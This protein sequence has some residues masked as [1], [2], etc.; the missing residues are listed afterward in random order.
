MARLNRGRYLMAVTGA[1]AA[2]AGLHYFWQRPAG[3]AVDAAWMAHVAGRVAA[4][5]VLYRDTFCGVTPLAFWIQ[6]LAGEWFGHTVGTVRGMLHALFVAQV[7]LVALIGETM[8]VSRLAMGA[9]L[10]GMLLWAAPLTSSTYSAWGV[11]FL[12]GA[13]W[14]A[15][16]APA[17]RRWA[18][19]AGVSAALAFGAKQ[20]VGVLALAMIVLMAPRAS[21]RMVA[22]FGVV[23][24]AIAL[25]VG[26]SGG[27]EEFVY[28][29]FTGKVTYLQTAGVSYWRGVDWRPRAILYL[30]PLGLVG[31]VGV[32]KWWPLVLLAVV[33]LAAVYPRPDPVHMVMAA[34][35]LVL[36]A[37]AVAA[38]HYWLTRGAVLV[39]VVLLVAQIGAEMYWVSQKGPAVVLHQRGLRGDRLEKPDAERIAKDLAALGSYGAGRPLFLLHPD[40]AFFYAGTGLKN[41][42]RYDY[43]LAT[44][45]GPT[46]QARVGAAI[47]AGEIRE[48]CLLES[49][50]PEL[51]PEELIATVRT[52]MRPAE[53]L[54]GAPCRLYRRP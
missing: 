45:F 25:L 3:A 44:T 54:P 2:W 28:Q 39:M 35:G 16:Q 5:E 1:A 49:P 34:P 11:V 4:G 53:E 26:A 41:P 29:C 22:G 31:L 51:P 17:D 24:A 7:L 20:N 38:R 47:R 46:G 14:A 12:L 36:A 50:W 37:A 30:L 32:R 15:A 42:L 21:G 23:V 19:G 18:Y 40:A 48:V 33:S 8:G 43:P 10:G 9:G 52:A 6:A 27:W 13:F